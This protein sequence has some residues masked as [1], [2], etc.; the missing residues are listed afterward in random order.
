[1][2]MDRICTRTA[3]IIFC[4]TSPKIQRLEDVGDP[5]TWEPSSC[6][7]ILPMQQAAFMHAD[8]AHDKGVLVLS[9]MLVC[10]IRLHLTLAGLHNSGG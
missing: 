3:H 6:G 1:M 5:W 2:T 4:R 10:M 9:L 8:H 7:S